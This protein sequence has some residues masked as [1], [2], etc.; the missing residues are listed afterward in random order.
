LLLR[1]GGSVYKDDR[2]A[3]IIGATPTVKA[4]FTSPDPDPTESITIDVL[5]CSTDP[6]DGFENY[7]GWS[8]ND[9]TITFPSGP[10]DTEGTFT[11]QTG[12]SVKSSIGKC[13][14][15]FL[16]RIYEVGGFVW[17]QDLGY[18][19]HNYYTVLDTPVAP[20]SQP[21]TEVLDWSCEQ[22][23]GQTTDTGSATEILQFLYND[24]TVYYDSW[25]DGQS[26]FTGSDLNGDFFKFTEFLD[27]APSI[28]PKV[29]CDDMGFALVTFANAIGC[30]M[31]YAKSTPFGYVNCILPV[32]GI[33]T[34][35]P[36]YPNTEKYSLPNCG[37]KLVLY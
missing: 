11:T 24:L 6:E 10:L 36:F 26:H 27:K 31:H 29:N 16:W 25:D 1:N 9:A 17:L 8:L 4:T 22:A 32:G 20:M 33:W 5:T 35:N 19:T 28:S 30:N 37:W 2:F 18:S 14:T 15:K 23:S 13:R 3:Y 7:T 21:W 34:N 12:T